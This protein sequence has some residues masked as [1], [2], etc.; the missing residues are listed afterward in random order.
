LNRRKWLPGLSFNPSFVLLSFCMIFAAIANAQSPASLTMQMIEPLPAAI[1]PLYY[2]VAVSYPDALRDGEFHFYVNGKDAPFEP[3]ASDSAAHENPRTFRVYLGEPGHKRI[4]VTLTA[5]NSTL[6]KATEIDFRSKGGMLLM[7]YFDGI[8]VFDTEDVYILT[9]FVRDAKVSVNGRAIKVRAEP[10]E[11]MEAL[12]QLSFMPELR[13]GS[14]LI[15]YS[16]TDHDGQPILRSFSIFMV[17]DGKVKVGDQINYAFGYPKRN[18][19]DP[20][21]S[22]HITG[23]AVVETG[24]LREVAVQGLSESSWLTEQSIFVQP[25]V[26]REVGVSNL[27]ITAVYSTGFRNKTSTTISVEPSGQQ[28]GATEK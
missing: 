7:G 15:E 14:N 5:N 17:V 10:V 18:E 20:D 4:E 16:G 25:I 6:R 19:A 26:A 3:L 13:P 27:E 24:S 8:A 2:R 22:L 23:T 1:E 9:Y 28:P 21:L 11:G 12:S